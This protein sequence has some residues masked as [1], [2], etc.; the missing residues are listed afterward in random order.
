MSFWDN[1]DDA[2]A[3]S[4]IKA[5]EKKAL[6]ECGIPFQVT[7][8]AYEQADRFEG[9][10]RYTL[11]ITVPNPETGEDEERLLPFPAGS[12]AESRDRMLAAMREY[13]DGGGDPVSCK[14]EQ[15]GRA[16]FLRQA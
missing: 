13:F 15:V 8:V 3:G 2:P 5:A 12:G 11:S 9:K 14:V 16:Y 4:Y 6:A 1:Y 10:P 7:A